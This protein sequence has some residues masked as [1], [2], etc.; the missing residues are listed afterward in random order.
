LLPAVRKVVAGM[1]KGD[2]SE[3]IRAPD[4]FHIIRLMEVKPAGTHTLAEATDAIRNALRQARQEEL[5]KAYIGKLI[6]S[7]P[8]TINGIALENLGQ[9]K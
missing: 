1:N 4:G 5:A 8:V 3:P 9:A 2:I 6:A 7:N